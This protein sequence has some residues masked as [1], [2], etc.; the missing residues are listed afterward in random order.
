MLRVDV[1]GAPVLL[2]RGNQLRAL[3]HVSDQFGCDINI[4]HNEDNELS[5]D[6]QFIHL[7]GALARVLGCLLFVRRIR[8]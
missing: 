5:S 4:T 1:F 3:V 7:E 2:E 6:C 8:L